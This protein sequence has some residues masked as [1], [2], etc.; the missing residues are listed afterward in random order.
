MGVS[1]DCLVGD[2]GGVGKL[3]GRTMGVSL[4]CMVGLWECQ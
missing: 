3:Y 2:Y 4:S 1:V